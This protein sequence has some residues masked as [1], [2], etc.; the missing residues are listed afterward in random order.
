MGGEYR[1]RGNVALQI[2]LAKVVGQRTQT[3]RVLFDTGSHKSFITAEAV[4]KIGSRPVQKERLSVVPFGTAGAALETRDVVEICLAPLRGKKKVT[5][6]Y[7]VVNNIY[8]IANVR[9]EVLRD[10]YPHLSVSGGNKN[11]TV[12][13]KVRLVRA[14]VFSV[15]LY[16]SESWTTKKSDDKKINSFELRCWRRLLRV[17]WTARRRNEWVLQ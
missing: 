12:E 13:T 16:G 3:V 8:S 17:P 14:L 9:P 1:I 4:A 15:V 11:I 2:A 6:Q 5:M 7:Y 10:N